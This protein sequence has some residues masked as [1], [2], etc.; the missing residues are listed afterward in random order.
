MLDHDLPRGTLMNHGRLVARALKVRRLAERAV[1]GLEEEGRERSETIAIP[2][3]SRAGQTGRRTGRRGETAWSGPA[4][5]WGRLG[6]AEAEAAFQQA[7]F[8][9][10]NAI[11]YGAKMRAALLLRDRVFSDLP[12]YTRWVLQMGFPRGRPQILEVLGNHLV[13][14]WKKA[15]RL[16]EVLSHRQLPE[17]DHTSSQFCHHEP[18]TSDRGPE[19]AHDRSEPGA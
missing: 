9:Y 2:E 14:F 3:V 18:G 12:S 6:P 11:T 13:D 16:N 17:A 5:R 15:H 1:M 8:S 7:D 19:P 4:I 10:R